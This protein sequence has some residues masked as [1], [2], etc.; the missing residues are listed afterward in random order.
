MRNTGIPS[1][2]I[3]KV[4]HGKRKE[5]GGFLWEFAQHIYFPSWADATTLPNGVNKDEIVKI[6][7]DEQTYRT[8]LAKV[9]AYLKLR[10]ER[11]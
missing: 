6:C 4:C 10:K 1:V 11:K 8:R 2:A 5:A 3:S 9:L 7:K